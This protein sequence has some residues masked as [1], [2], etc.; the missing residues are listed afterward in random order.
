MAGRA[1]VAGSIQASQAHRENPYFRMTAPGV[2]KA[3]Y[4]AKA[5][6]II[7]QTGAQIGST[8]TSLGMWL[9]EAPLREA[10]LENAK[11]LNDK[12]KLE[13]QGLKVDFADKMSQYK[14]TY[15]A[16]VKN[17]ATNMPSFEDYISN[18]VEWATSLSDS[19]LNVDKSPTVT[20]G[21]KHKSTKET[22][23]IDTSEITKSVK[24]VSEIVIDESDDS[25]NNNDVNAS[26][27]VP[28]TLSGLKVATTDRANFNQ[29]YDTSI[30]RFKNMVSKV[31]NIDREYNPTEFAVAAT[32]SQHK[33]DPNWRPKSG[34]DSTGRAVAIFEHTEINKDGSPKLD[35]NG[36]PVIN[37]ASIPM[38]SF[39]AEGNFWSPIEIPETFGNFIQT[40]GNDLKLFASEY[41][42]ADKIQ[43][44]DA[45]WNEMSN[46]FDAKS[47]SP[48]FL[49][50]MNNNLSI[51]S[52]GNLTE[53]VDVD[54]N[55][56]VDG[57]DFVKMIKPFV[58]EGRVTTEQFARNKGR[59]SAI[60]QITKD[61]IVDNRKDSI[62]REKSLQT[63]NSALQSIENTNNEITE[64]IT[65][66]DN[67]LLSS[68][69][70][71]NPADITFLE[72]DKGNV[73]G[74]EAKDRGNNKNPNFKSDDI[75][76][77][78]YLNDNNDLKALTRASFK[79][80]GTDEYKKVDKYFDS[81]YDKKTSV[82]ETVEDVKDR[83][84]DGKTIL[85][86]SESSV[87]NKFKVKKVHQLPAQVQS[88][89]VQ[90]QSERGGLDNRTDLLTYLEININ[91][92]FDV[93]L[94]L[95]ELPEDV[96]NKLVLYKP[97]WFSL[98][99]K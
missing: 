22:T 96:R 52:K 73:V 69:T 3:Q 58:N 63:Q 24:D 4:D 2:I 53:I 97:Y 86:K 55:K 92:D 6:Q 67:K 80:R 5:A 76:S 11:L 38:S 57:R 16:L 48:H 71:V 62:N 78:Y 61:N 54:G 88:S 35:N 28:I 79:T 42:N 64:A 75:D 15:D 93:S 43:I 13:N 17:G 12:I 60:T 41:G 9:K 50:S 30:Q 87:K 94:G 56:T 68:L 36:N 89:L 40:N 45:A 27:N 44:S 26:S 65:S 37:S 33:D 49:K 84:V 59:E 21:R 18:Q 39:K 81:F 46:L 95:S 14:V 74:F 23:P 32:L 10:K 51:L 31:Q 66:Q 25:K 19:I 29:N 91:K 70:N 47:Q 34:F 83:K 98:D 8:L 1:N 77:T 82:T 72:D 7:G 90:R 99:K 20:N 85:G